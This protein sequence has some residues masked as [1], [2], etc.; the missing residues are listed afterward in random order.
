MEITYL[1]PVET[2]PVGGI[3]V[4]YKHSEILKKMGVLSSVYHPKNPDFVC[5]WFDHQATTRGARPLVTGKDFVVIPEV[6]ALGMGDRC[7]KTNTDYA[8]F[9]QGGYLLESGV[10]PQQY[11]RL[12]EI[13]EG[14]KPKAM[15]AATAAATTT[16]TATATTTTMATTAAVE[17]LSVSVMVEMVSDDI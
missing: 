16:T 13:Y 5:S 9:V 12:K 17:A 2:K 10:P 15:A 4:I 3:K 1:C 7:L 11:D 8:V 14:A 6:W